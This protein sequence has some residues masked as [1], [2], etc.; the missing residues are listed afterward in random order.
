MGSRISRGLTR[1]FKK[2]IAETKQ[3]DDSRIIQM[4]SAMDFLGNLDVL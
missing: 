2:I 3:K 4:S 1:S